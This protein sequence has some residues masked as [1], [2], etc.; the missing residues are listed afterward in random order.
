MP[1]GELQQRMSSREFTEWAA[2]YSLSPFGDERGDLQAGIVAST[3]ANALRTEK[4]KHFRPGD[5]MPVF[6]QDGQER[7]P[8]DLLAIVEQIN[9]AFGGRDLR[10]R[11]RDGNAG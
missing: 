7:S 10:G 1:V 6:E 5:F 3:I 11:G 8:E 9:A 4:S 2:Y